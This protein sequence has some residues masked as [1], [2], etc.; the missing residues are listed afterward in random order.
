M[1]REWV[2][3]HECAREALQWGNPQSTDRR[4]LSSG[5]HSFTLVFASA[6][7]QRQAIAQRVAAEADPS[8]D[9]FACPPLRRQLSTDGDDAISDASPPPPHVRIAWSELLR[10]TFADP[11]VCPRC[12]ARMRLVAVVKDPNAIAAILA[13]PAHH[14]DDPQ[15]GPDPPQLPRDLEPQRELFKAASTAAP[16]SLTAIGPASIGRA[17]P[18][19]AQQ[20]DF[21]PHPARA[22]G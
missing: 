18:T 20:G 3:D 13:H 2:T 1:G 14:D 5:T 16:S 9:P 11:L 15:S 19:A 8:D 21:C 4:P 12:Q 22:G 7:G 6:H 10:R 17:A